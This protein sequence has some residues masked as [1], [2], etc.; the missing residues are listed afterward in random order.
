MNTSAYVRQVKVVIPLHLS[1]NSPNKKK[2]R[3]NCDVDCWVPSFFPV[4]AQGWISLTTESERKA[5]RSN[6]DNVAY[7]L[8]KNRK[9]HSGIKL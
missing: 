1:E 8:V 6:D 9:H 2:K 5:L 7:H 4:T 3:G